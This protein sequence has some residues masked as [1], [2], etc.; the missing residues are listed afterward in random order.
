MLS[1]FTFAGGIGKGGE[2]F[3]VE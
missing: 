1:D 3:L 2:E